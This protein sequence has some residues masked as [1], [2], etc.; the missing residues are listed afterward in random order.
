MAASQTAEPDSAAAA[1]AAGAREACCEHR[2]HEAV[3]QLAEVVT[4][5]TARTGAR[6]VRIAFEG[7]GH[8]MLDG[9]YAAVTREAAARGWPDGVDVVI[10][11]GDFQA[12]RNPADLTCLSVPPRF[13]RLG[14]FPAYYAGAKAAP[15]LT[16]FV[17]GNHEASNY[18]SELHYG[19]WV[20]PNIYYLGAAN[21]VRFAG[22]R[23]AGLSGIFAPYDYG[24]PHFERLPYNANDAKSVYHTRQL[25]VRKLMQLRTPVDIVVSH[26]WPQGIEHHGDS[27]WLFRHKRGFEEDSRSGKLGSPAA[28]DVLHR[29]RPK[30]WLSAHLHVKFEA[31]VS[32]GGYDPLSVFVPNVARR[33]AQKAA[34]AVAA[35]E[36]AENAAA[37]RE[38]WMEKVRE[39]AEKARP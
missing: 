7:C 32:H 26:D 9:I 1:A 14:D 30:L 13:R 16:L 20:A 5:E 34:A 6:P 3:P 24:R 19:G 4:A 35:A 8:G 39:S 11:G 29:L 25:D 36:A 2:E 27:R 17:G 38:V 28:R 33:A 37:E 15:Y 12:V 31:V 23:I 22:L 18:L 10:I 21:V